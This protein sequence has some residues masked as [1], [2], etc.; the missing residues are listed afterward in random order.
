MDNLTERDRQEFALVEAAARSYP[1][2]GIPPDFSAAVM[3]R[4]RATS[5]MPRFRVTWQDI[6]LSLFIAGVAVLASAVWFSLPP[7]TQMYVQMRIILFGQTLLFAFPGW[8]IL[9]SFLLMIVLFLV[10]II[11]LLRPRHRSRS[12]I[13]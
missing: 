13:M 4:V 3:N 7:Q 9:A 2:A 1:L 8:L 11:R 5:P 10:A 12:G 6:I